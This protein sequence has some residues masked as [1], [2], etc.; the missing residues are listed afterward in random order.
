MLRMVHHR[1]NNLLIPSV[2]VLWMT[3]RTLE[4]LLHG[5]SLAPKLLKPSHSRTSR[6][7]FYFVL[8]YHQ[9]FF[10]FQESSHLNV[11]ATSP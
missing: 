1:S 11:S 6:I 4:D 2:E 3:N 5:T 9:F 8:F 7:P 10:K